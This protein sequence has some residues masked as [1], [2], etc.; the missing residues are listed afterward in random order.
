ML[1]R[2]KVFALWFLT[3]VGLGCGIYF[4]PK[5]DEALTELLFLSATGIIALVSTCS[6]IILYK[7]NEMWPKSG[8]FI[9]GGALFFPSCMIGLLAT[10]LSFTLKNQAT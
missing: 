8:Y 10:D 1:R 6:L 4:V 9:I 5:K 3:V 2:T 7:D